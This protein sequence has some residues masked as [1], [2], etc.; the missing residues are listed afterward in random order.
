MYMPCVVMLFDATMSVT[1]AKHTQVHSQ[2]VR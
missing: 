2:R 1:C